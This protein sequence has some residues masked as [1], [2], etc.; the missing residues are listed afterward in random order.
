MVGSGARKIKPSL[1]GIFV[2]ITELR[3]DAMPEEKEKGNAVGTKP[4]KK[5][6]NFPCRHMIFTN[7]GLFLN[8]AD[9]IE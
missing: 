2:Q 9:P 4:T 3:G 7:N 8:N 1:E 6:R 5:N